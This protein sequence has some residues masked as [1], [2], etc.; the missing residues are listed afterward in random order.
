MAQGSSAT[1]RG[2]TTD[3]EDSMA[4][5]TKTDPK[6][7][8]RGTVVEFFVDKRLTL[9]VCLEAKG[10]VFDPDRGRP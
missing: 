10:S 5:P 3:L 7:Q 6:A 1:H 4:T 2:E 9:G 8:W